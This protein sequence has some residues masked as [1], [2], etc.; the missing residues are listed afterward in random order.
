[1]LSLLYHIC[2]AA[3]DIAI[4][5]LAIRVF[6][7]REPIIS[8]IQVSLLFLFL[9][10]LYSLYSL[11]YIYVMIPIYLLL[12]LL[13]YKEKRRRSQL[14]FS[15][16]GFIFLNLFLVPILN[17]VYFFLFNGYMDVDLSSFGL[18]SNQNTEFFIKMT[19]LLVLFSIRNTKFDTYSQFDNRYLK[20]SNIFM[21]ICYMVFVIFMAISLTFKNEK[22]FI[23]LSL[24]SSLIISLAFIFNNLYEN[25]YENINKNH[26]LVIEN[27]KSKLEL[28]GLLE[29]QKF[30]EEMKKFRHDIKNNFMVIEHMIQYKEYEAAKNYLQKYIDDY[31]N[32]QE[33][34]QIDNLVVSAIINDK[35]R[36]YSALGFDVRC[37]IPS[38]LVIEDVDL[39][40]ILGNLLDNA[41]EYLTRENI[42]CE[43]LIK[44]STISETDLFIEL[45]NPC[46]SSAEDPKL[47]KTKKSDTSNHGY[48]IMIVEDTV[49]KYNGLYHN[50]V[51]NGNFITQILIPEGVKKNDTHQ[52]A[53]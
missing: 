22:L 30:V 48:G 36:R 35:I 25:L 31:E 3:S 2:Q 52:K 33:S 17:I 29:S 46:K 44:V 37:F 16:C 34:I 15:L 28:A 12:I 5:L 14:L 47:L 21:L 41:C 9:V 51:I 49:S 53:Q 45:N 27:E 20:Y 23:M 40:K 6:A 18:V 1:M 8:K 32:S 4:P 50:E 43:I 38:K 10:T 39:A 19:L 7:K 42:Y 13:N 24:L 26:L 11:N